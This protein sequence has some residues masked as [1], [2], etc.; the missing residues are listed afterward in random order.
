MRT[1]EQI[2]EEILNNRGIVA[3][4]DI[5]EF[6]SQKP[7]KTHDPFLLDDMQAGVDLLLSVVNGEGSTGNGRICIY[8]DYDA[9]GVTASTVMACAVNSLTGNWFFYVPSRFTEGYGLN[10]KALDKI[11]DAGAELI[12][13]VDC[14]CVSHDEVEYAKSIGLKIIVT[15]HHNIEDVIADCI[16]I[17]P[18]KTTHFLPDG[19]MPYP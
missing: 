18:K 16:V 13:T 12:I 19:V 4:E 17:D 8:G 1:N 10:L 5:R 11:K 14:G 6:L 15:D 3:E 7:N 2:V 9:D